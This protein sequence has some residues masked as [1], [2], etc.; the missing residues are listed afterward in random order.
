M[1]ASSLSELLAS[2]LPAT[3]RERAQALIQLQDRVDRSLP[4]AL[5][6]HVRV[7]Q[8]AE[9]QLRLACDSGAVA[10]RLRHLSESLIADLA[11]RGVA[12][13]SLRVGVNPELLATSTPPVAKAGLPASALASLAQLGDDIDEGPLKQALGRLLRHHRQP[14]EG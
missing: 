10:S 5:T 4:A 2:Q 8:L 13:K 6:G 7:L 9:G 1:S 14:G 3:L 12:V 11:A